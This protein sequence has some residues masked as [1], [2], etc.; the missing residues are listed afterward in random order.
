MGKSTLHW[1]TRCVNAVSGAPICEGLG[2]R[3]YARINED[4]TLGSA[5]IPDD[6]REALTR[7]DDFDKLKP[8]NFQEAFDL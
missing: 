4:G 7:F 2:T 6:M 5:T 8:V 1:K 3:V